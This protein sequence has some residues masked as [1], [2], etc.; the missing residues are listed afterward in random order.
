MSSKQLL[1]RK[2]I[3]Q[4]QALSHQI[5]REK[6]DR[7][8]HNLQALPLFQEAKTILAYFSLKKEPDLSILFKQK[9]QHNW[10]FPRCVN[11]ELIWHLWQPEAKIKKGNYGVYEPDLNLPLIKVQEVDLIL[12]P[13]LACDTQGFRL[14]YGA[15]YYDRMLSNSS[16]QSIPTIGIVF[17]QYVYSQLPRDQ[18]DQKLDFVATELRIL[19]S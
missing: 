9:D 13:A 16:W 4:R 11:K 7:L 10:G 12:V 6:S 17:E 8:C 15:G 19:K 3:S 14:G 2:I 5:W 18:W 1:R